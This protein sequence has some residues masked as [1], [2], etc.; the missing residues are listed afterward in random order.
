MIF[1]EMEQID[2]LELLLGE[3]MQQTYEC[4]VLIDVQ[5]GTARRIG[6]DAVAK[7][8]KKRASGISYI[9]NFD[10][11]IKEN[12]SRDYMGDDLKSVLHEM[13]IETMEKR[14]ETE[15]SSGISFSTYEKGKTR[16]KYLEYRYLKEMRGGICLTKQDITKIYEEERHKSRLVENALDIA[17]KANQA[18]S[19]FLL[20]VSHDVR[21][22]LYG[23]NGMLDF[24]MQPGLSKEE[25]LSYL[26]KA[27]KSSDELTA[28]VNNMLDMSVVEM[29]KLI[30]DE[31]AVNMKDF[32]GE[33]A[34]V[35]SITAKEKN[36]QVIFEMEDERL[37]F[38]KIDSIR[39]SQVCLL[40]MG[41]SLQ[42]GREGGYAKCVITAEEDTGDFLRV[43]LVFSDNGIGMD[44]GQKQRAF[45]EFVYES[46][47]QGGKGLGLS[48]ARSI[49]YKAGGT[50]QLES[51]LG[52]GTVV[53][54]EIHCRKATLAEANFKNQVDHMVRKFDELDFG[55]FRALVVDDNDI[56][57]EITTLKLEHFGLQVDTARDGQE[58]I[59]IL[60]ASEENY[61]DIVFM[62]VQMPVKNGLQATMEIRQ[63]ERQD[64]SDITIVAITAHAFRDERIET[65]ESGMDYHLPLPVDDMELKEILAKELFNLTPQKEFEARG[66]RVIK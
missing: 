46:H 60:N 61:Y 2:I 32:L 43:K 50:M 6:F 17:Q 28:L 7:S 31:Q 37:S 13:C 25:I 51:S 35:L 45:Q 8:E 49:V 55:R 21:T 27:K 47:K 34:A 41:N 1:R 52:K 39:L 11:W 38:I 59:D 65:L 64:L 10:A 15:I 16:R 5:A 4:I 40:I 66:F 22:P 54:V 26:E 62:D 57:R 20:N 24:A 56:G 36:Q 23:M 14:L 63:S 58:A 12:L 29:G 3:L 42:Y 48:L 44:E 30:I 53:T 18:K 9:Q 19:E 33:L